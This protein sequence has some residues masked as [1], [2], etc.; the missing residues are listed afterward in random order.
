[1]FIVGAFTLF[2]LAVFVMEGK[3]DWVLGLI[4]SL[5]NG[6]GAWLGSRFAVVK[7]EKWVRAILVVAVLVMAVRL[8]G[9]IPGW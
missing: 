7:G 2:A 1:V 8:S 5:G 9:I 6:V 4:L 3:V